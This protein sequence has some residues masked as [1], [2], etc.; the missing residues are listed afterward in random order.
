MPLFGGSRDRTR[1]GSRD[2]PGVVTSY[3]STLIIK[4]EVQMASALLIDLDGV[5][6]T[7]RHQ[8][9]GAI[10][11]RF[12]LP[13]GAI[14]QVAFAPERLLPVITGKVP[15]LTW[16]AQIC[17]ELER[18]FPHASVAEAVAWWSEPCG[19][20][21]EEV[22]EIVRR[23]RRRAVVVLVT[24]ATSRLPDDLRQLG[25]AHEFDH[26]VN[27][28]VVGYAKPAPQ[29]FSAALAAAG[30]SPADAIFVDDTP[31]HVVAARRF[32]IIAHHYTTP[33]ALRD[34]LSAHGLLAG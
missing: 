29:I 30:V 16:R 25:I 5:I 14:R 32:G 11:A 4:G 23:C 28:S 20:L 10:A 13:P 7:W 24:N 31:G 22:L 27:S 2:G 12:G 3:S 8:E 21:T 33:A 15:D 6:R 17:A 26:V 18:Q 19:E 34:E 9:D 1:A